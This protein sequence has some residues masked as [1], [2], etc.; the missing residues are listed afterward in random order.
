MKILQVHNTYRFYGGEDRVY[1]SIVD[2]LENRGH[3]IAKLERNSRNLIGFHGK[4]RAFVE[5]IYSRSAIK[6]LLNTIKVNRPDIV[7]IH[8][9]YPLISPSILPVLRRHRIPV[10][11]TCHNYRLTCPIGVHLN[12]DR[13][14]DKCL[15]DHEYW[16]ILK[17]CRNNIFESVAFCLRSVIARQLQIFQK[18]VTIFVTPTKFIKQWLIKAGFNEDKFAVIP[19]MVKSP[20][21]EREFSG[22]DYVAYVGRISP[23]KGVDTI[24]KAASFLPDIKIKIAGD[25]PSLEEYKKIA[26]HNTEFIGL[27]NR[28]KVSAFYSKARFVIVPSK[29]F[30]V[31]PLVT[32][33][34]MSHG[35]P[36][37][38][39]NVGGL[40]EIVDDGVTGLLFR[41]EKADDLAKKIKILW[42]NKGLCKRMGKVAQN[43]FNLR[44]CEDAYYRRL[45]KVYKNLVSLI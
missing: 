18:N 38:A 2:L 31:F 11:M 8:N 36:V 37:V 22:K 21:C 12:S 4:I 34:A 1:R 28:K 5:G 33:E 20:A 41:P 10:V 3:K 7:H 40:P 14:C 45:I 44:Y 43:M 19:N 30:E 25:G 42:N 17:D 16:C 27:L 9:L 29:C 23:E 13:I 35:L 32:A 6:E 24:L 26:P 15:D 39:S